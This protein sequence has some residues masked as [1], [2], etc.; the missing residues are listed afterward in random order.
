MKMKKIFLKSKNKNIN[1][2]E[3]N[4]DLSLFLKII[5]KKIESEKKNRNNILA[6][7]LKN[8]YINNSNK[9]EYE[10][11]IKRNFNSNTIDNV[12]D[13]KIKKK[14]IKVK[15]SR[16]LTSKSSI[17]SKK[18][19]EISNSSAI[20]TKKMKI[21]NIVVNPSEYFRNNP[22]DIN[23]SISLNNINNYDIY[24]NPN[25]LKFIKLIAKLEIKNIMFRYFIL[26]KKG[27]K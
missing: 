5:N 1:I 24:F 18:S 21:R 17:S 2:K 26:W 7:Y 27:K 25:T 19:E 23:G 10:N 20:H 3:I 15:F 11:K 14:H 8:W 9:N 4:L 6:K 13:K 16:T 12:K 22:I